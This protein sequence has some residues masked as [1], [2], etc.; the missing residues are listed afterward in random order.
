M[1]RFIKQDF[2]FQNISDLFL[3][4]LFFLWQV[5]DDL[6]FFGQE[7][8][9]SAFTG[10]LCLCATSFSLVTAWIKSWGERREFISQVHQEDSQENTTVMKKEKGK[11]KQQ[12]TYARSF[13][14]ALSAFSLWMCSIR[15]RLFLKTL[16]LVFR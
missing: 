15:M 8:L 13:L 2:F 7:T 16:P 14:R 9:L 11:E 4:S 6:L 12:A 3:C 5:L 10:L 1:P